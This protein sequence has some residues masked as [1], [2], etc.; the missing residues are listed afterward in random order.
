MF[1]VSDII[2]C[3]SISWLA[4]WMNVSFSHQSIVSRGPLSEEA[5]GSW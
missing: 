3:L 5:S 4:K 1:L 2:F